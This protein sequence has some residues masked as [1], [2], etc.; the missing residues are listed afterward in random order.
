[1]I[2]RQEDE[3]KRNKELQE[4]AERS[5]HALPAGYYRKEAAASD[6]STPQQAAQIIR[7]LQQRNYGTAERHTQ[8]LLWQLMDE[9]AQDRKAKAQADTFK[10]EMEYRIK[11][12]TEILPAQRQSYC[13]SVVDFSEGMRAGYKYALAIYE[14]SH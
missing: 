6:E 5:L 12:I 1:M 10:A 2:K 11:N 4:L 14:G 8:T 7:D 9:R 3:E 13:S